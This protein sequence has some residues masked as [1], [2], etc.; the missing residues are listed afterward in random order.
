MSD[1]KLLTDTIQGEV[2]IVNKNLS[3]TT[4]LKITQKD[5]DKY[6]NRVFKSMPELSTQVT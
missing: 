2:I 1:K 4:M 5:D 6:W 3:D